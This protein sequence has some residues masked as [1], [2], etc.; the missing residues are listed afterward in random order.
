MYPVL[1]AIGLA[2]ATLTL[3]GY[4]EPIARALRSQWT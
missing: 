3:V 1:L 4:R 2:I